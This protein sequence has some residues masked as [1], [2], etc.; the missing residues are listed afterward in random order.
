MKKLITIIVLALIGIGWTNTMNAQSGSRK[1]T[2]HGLLDNVFDKNGNNYTLD[3]IKIDSVDDGQ[4]GR[5]LKAPLL[6]TSGYFNLYFETGSGMEGAG[7]PDID[8]RAIICQ[9]F[10]DISAF[11]NSPLSNMGNSNKVNIWVRDIN[12]C[13]TPINS[14]STSNVLGLATSFYNATTTPT[15][16]FGGIADGEIWKTIISGV[17]SYTNV[18]PP[19]YTNGGASS[20][21]GAFYHGMIAFNFDNVGISWNTDLNDISCVNKHDLYSLAL[22]EIT[23]ALGFASLIDYN[24]YSRFG[25][26]YNY[27]SRFDLKLK[28]SASNGSLNLITNSGACNSMYNYQFNPA[29]LGNIANV[30]GSAPNNT[31][32]TDQ[33]PCASAVIYSGATTVPVYTPVIYETGSSLSHFEDECYVPSGFNPQPPLSNN[34]YYSMSNASSTG[35]QYVKRYLKPEE[36]QVLCDLGYSTNISYGSVANNTYYLYSS[37]AC[38]GIGVSGIDDGISS[39]TGGYTYMGT[40]AATISGI[41]NND[42]NANTFICL[43]D[44]TDPTATLSATSGNASANVILTPAN[45]PTGIHL[46]RYVPVSITG[47]KGN[48][49]YIYVYFLNPNCTPLSCDMVNNGDFE[50]AT[51][52]AW[53][54]P[55]ASFYQTSVN[56]WDYLS[57][58]PELMAR[59]CSSNSGVC[60]VGTST[61]NSIPATD[62][63]T[64]LPNVSN[65]NT[66]NDK[67]ILLWSR[68]NNFVWF[69][70]AAQTILNAPLINGTQYV[71]KFWAKIHNNVAG[72]ST[73]N[74]PTTVTFTSYPNIVVPFGIGTL[75]NGTGGS[76]VLSIPNSVNLCNPILI[77]ANVSVSLSNSP[78]ADWYPYS[79]S[80]TFNGSSSYSYNA[81]GVSLGYYPNIGTGGIDGRAVFLDDISIEPAATATTL[82]LPTVLCINQTITNLGLNVNGTPGGVFTGAG[83]SNNGNQYT[84]DASVAGVGNHIITYIYYIGGCGPYFAGQTITVNAGSLSVS[85]T[86]SPTTVMTGGTS[87]LTATSAGATS[88]TWQPGNITTTNTSITVNPLVTTTYTVTATNGTCSA[89]TTV[90]VTVQT[91]PP[92][93]TNLIF[94]Y[95][96]QP[97]TTINS[98]ILFPGMSLVASTNIT[99]LANGVL[100]IDKNLSISNCNI[101]MGENARINLTVGDLILKDR[102]HIFSCDDVTW[103]EINIPTGRTLKVTE[104]S[105]IEDANHAIVSQGGGKYDVDGAIFNRNKTAIEVLQYVNIHPG[106]IKNAIFT[107]RDIVSNPNPSINFTVANLNLNNY[108]ATLQPKNIKG[109]NNR[110]SYGVYSTDVKQLNIGDA[111]NA[112]N[113]NKFDNLNYGIYLNRTSSII[114]NNT[115]QNFVTVPNYTCSGNLA[116]FGLGTQTG[117]SYSIQIGTGATTANLY[118]NTF[119][120]VFSGIFIKYY[121]YNTIRNNT[122]SNILTNATTGFV[123]MEIYPSTNN[124]VDI[125]YNRITNFKLG[126]WLYRDLLGRI[127]ATNTHIEK[128]KIYGDGTSGAGSCTNAITVTDLGNGAQTTVPVKIEYNTISALQNG[129]LL[130]GIIANN[131]NGALIIAANNDSITNVGIT[132]NNPTTNSG[133]GIEIDKCVNAT[134]AKNTDIHSVGTLGNGVGRYNFNYKGI[135]VNL[136]PWSSVL[137]NSVH[138]CGQ[139]MTFK[140]KCFPSKVLNNSLGYGLRGF[141]LDQAA[142]PLGNIGPQGLPNNGMT[143]GQTCGLSWTWNSFVFDTYT[144]NNANPAL[145]KLYLP[146]SAIPA[147]S[148]NG[149]NWSNPYSVGNGFSPLYLY[150]AMNCT[151]VVITP[152]FAALSTTELKELAFDSTQSALYQQELQYHNKMIAYEI[153]DST[154]A[155]TQDTTGQLQLFYDSAKVAAL[156]QLKDVSKYIVDKNYTAANSKNG[157]VFPSNGVEANQKAVN[158]YYLLKLQDST[159]QYTP[160]D[161]TAIYAIAAQC[162]SEGGAVI[163]EARVLYYG[164]INDIINFENNCEAIGKSLQH[165]SKPTSDNDFVLYPNPNDGTMTL[166]YHLNENDN[167]DLMLYDIAGRTIRSFQINSKSTVLNIDE[168]ELN[169]G[170][171]Y[172]NLRVNDK[173]YKNGKIVIIK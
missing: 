143:P 60:N 136:S 49:T 172:Y 23:H 169:A 120:N 125:Y 152:Q 87:T 54:G 84:F 45:V 133:S 57:D 53:F 21:S 109:T 67:F 137:C 114:Y 160:E 15:T 6:C 16:G 115:F 134:I 51:N 71:L 26:Y 62:S 9:V 154:D 103:D 90:T 40:A 151:G 119:T 159:Y 50:T 36:K 140:D 28:S 94:P 116:I 77:P 150:T 89:S 155:M 97:G 80:F 24:G 29:L 37:G 93:C 95:V 25:S 146:S 126:I 12:P 149:S 43:E 118:S 111:S 147:A 92:Q 164:I 17:N 166:K 86:A 113:N 98:S 52:C 88:Y 121:T 34:L 38:A 129:S 69:S 61:Y 163:W 31:P 138:D 18:S 79:I 65:N 156:G 135:F 96:V 64:G 55:N 47:N 110:S 33:T 72:T 165:A 59:N 162:P 11:I 99:I 76:P 132:L 58:D 112:V 78:M 170:I 13:L 3:S 123:G 74:L 32:S 106:T 44:I 83:V 153:L 130:N 70:K 2:P 73:T 46:L 141:V 161:S 85:A 30:I 158:Y 56:C 108:V 35:S 101:V 145:S 81:L 122:F 27:Y 127:N 63:H 68:N 66:I 171:Y 82:N 139:S 107:C 104:S 39:S 131:V 42:Y 48:I 167:A 128:N 5:M 105:F 4:G 173:I 1:Y 75:A 148:L 144:S 102:T 124:S 10:S 7:S 168:S 14:A 19:L 41:L 8:R 117:G 157:Q 20:T 142:L 22:H 100:N 91:A